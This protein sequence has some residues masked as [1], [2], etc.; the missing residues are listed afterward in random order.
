MIW[1]TVTLGFFC[2][3]MGPYFATV[4]VFFVTLLALFKIYDWYQ[5]HSD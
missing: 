1:T 5:A 3:A 2:M 4:Y